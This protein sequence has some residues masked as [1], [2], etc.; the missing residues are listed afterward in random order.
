MT[1]SELNIGL[2]S[3][4]HF[5]LSSSSSINAFGVFL[6]PSAV[7]E[8]K[9]SVPETGF[10]IKPDTPFKVPVRNPPNPFFLAPSM[11]FS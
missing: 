7:L 2:G 4:I 8:I 11:G 10:V 1:W 5:N 9:S 3:L 6:I